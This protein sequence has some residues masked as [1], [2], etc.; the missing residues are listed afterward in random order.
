L[1][2]LDSRLQAPLA[3]LPVKDLPIWPIP[4]AAKNV[5]CL[6]QTGLMVSP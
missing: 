1:Q 6:M 5:Y 3:I 2:E 4:G